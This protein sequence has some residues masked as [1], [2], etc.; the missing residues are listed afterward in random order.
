MNH[1]L[2]HVKVARLRLINENE[3]RGTLLRRALRKY[4]QLSRVYPLHKVFIYFVEKIYAKMKYSILSKV[5]KKISLKWGHQRSSLSE[6][7][8]SKTS[9][10]IL[11]RNQQVIDDGKLS[12]D[13]IYSIRITGG[14]GDA[15]IIARLIR[16]LQHELGNSAIFDVYFHSPKIV[17]LF[18]QNIPGFREAIHTDAFE[19]VVPYYHFSLIANQ[20]VLFVNKHINHRFLLS[21]SPKVLKIFG[22]VQN[23]RKLIDKY[24]F[25]H[26]ALDGAFADVAVKSG[27]RRATYLHELLG[28]TYGGD[29]LNIPLDST[30]FSKYKLSPGEYITIHDGWDTK[31]KL[32]ALR[33]TKSYPLK[34]WE[35]V[36]SE[37]KKS[38]PHINIVQI[39]GR[40][41]SAIPKVDYN[42]KEKISFD[43]SVTILSGSMLHID[44]ESG[45]V[46]L[47]T[48][49]GVHSVVIF[50]PT[51]VAW[52]GYPQNIN[53]APKL[54]GNC[55]WST[56]NWMDICPI[57]HD[58]PVCTSA[59]S[60]SPEEVAR[61]AV[62][63]IERRRSTLIPI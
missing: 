36:V 43:E 13:L 37:I 52:F 35:K 15:L 62:M 19:A 59:D 49:L 7:V 29:R 45:L 41:G 57:G 61:N 6:Y 40:T 10:E 17:E 21:K 50:G 1:N 32:V 46:H 55:W 34:N 4:H 56:D 48:A 63:M 60:I 25:A 12:D 20:F 23:A 38:L 39:G 28:L 8:F 58:I 24:I 51:N 5:I 47:A 44:T 22:R 11:E 54:C 30:V 33:P 31:F 14:I 27:H 2:N 26:P 18:F 16:D 3:N 9:K 53:I 42:L